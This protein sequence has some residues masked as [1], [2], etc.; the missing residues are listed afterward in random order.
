MTTTA[1]TAIITTCMGRLHH[2]KQS[3]PSMLA[4][5][6]EVIV[7]CYGDAAAYRWCLSQPVKS[8]F[9]DAHYWNA[10]V[11]RNVGA[12]S[13]DKAVFAFCDVDQI[14]PLTYLAESLHLLGTA[15]MLNVQKPAA[16]GE[17][18][19]TGN[20][21]ISAAAFHLVRGYDEQF[22]DY[23]VEDVDLYARV[24]RDTAAPTLSWTPPIGYISH[25]DL[26]SQK[27][28][29]VSKS[30]S[31]A[32]NEAYNRQRG[33][34]ALVNPYGYGKAQGVEC[35]QK[36]YPFRRGVR[37]AGNP[38]PQTWDQQT[39]NDCLLPQVPGK[40]LVLEIGSWNGFSAKKILA[41]AEENCR[42]I[43]CDP[44][45][46][47]S[48]PSNPNRDPLVYEKFLENLEPFAHRIVPQR[49]FSLD[50]LRELRALGIAPDLIYIDGDHE[51]AVETDIELSCT[52]WPDAV[53]VGDDYQ[54]ERAVREAAHTMATRYDRRLEVMGN[55]W[56]MSA[57]SVPVNFQPE[58]TLGFVSS[59]AEA[60]EQDLRDS[61]NETRS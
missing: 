15:P 40:S 47:Y 23:G 49:R 27:N 60:R 42:L 11:A 37:V 61:R 31:I 39:I 48:A 17:I 14:L 52:F 6:C 56:V 9:V 8:L 45:Q 3:L 34:E 44:W 55:G 19:F 57:A 2:L 1:D 4:Q 38:G 59:A 24:L 21:M 5:G 10:A 25:G 36:I 22:A 26:D 16:N 54:T 28:A 32:R 41:A 20:C 18:S 30:E 13:C 53:L 43:C 58:A 50:G 29:R 51:I 35:L 7:V 46:G 12:M 33:R